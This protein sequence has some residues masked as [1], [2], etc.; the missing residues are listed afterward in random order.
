MAM[1][2]TSDTRVAAQ[3]SSQDHQTLLHNGSNIAMVTFGIGGNVIVGCPSAVTR[4]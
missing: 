1:A 3:I 2:I 4:R